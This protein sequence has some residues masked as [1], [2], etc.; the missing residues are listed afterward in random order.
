M[1]VEATWILRQTLKY[2]SFHFFYFHPNLTHFQKVFVVT[3]GITAAGFTDTTEKSIMPWTSREWTVVGSAPLPNKMAGAA[4]VA[5][6][7]KLYLTG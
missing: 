1:H 7:N 4:I 2:I 6:Y 5:I 3:G